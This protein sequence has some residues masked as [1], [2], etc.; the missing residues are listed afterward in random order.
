MNLVGIRILNL[1][2]SVLKGNLQTSGASGAGP[3]DKERDTK[4]Q[5]VN[6]HVSSDPTNNAPIPLIFF[7]GT[8]FWGGFFPTNVWES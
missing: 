5:H 4:K 6:I 8:L 1:P 3:L 2:T 7:P